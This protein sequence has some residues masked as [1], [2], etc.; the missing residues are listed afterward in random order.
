MSLLCRMRGTLRGR[1]LCCSSSAYSQRLNRYAMIGGMEGLHP[2]IERIVRDRGHKYI[3]FSSIESAYHNKA[4]QDIDGLIVDMQT[5]VP[6]HVLSSGAQHKLKII[7]RA[8]GSLGNGFI[9]VVEASCFG[10][11]ILVTHGSNADA[12]SIAEYAVGLILSQAR[13]V[14][15]AST[16]LTVHNRW[17]RS[18]YTGAELRGKVM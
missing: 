10:R 4:F 3:K 16:S 2:S 1:P 6:T 15:Q 12:T 13:N 9:D 18:R 8:A 7:G 11:G 5:V 14:P 17:D